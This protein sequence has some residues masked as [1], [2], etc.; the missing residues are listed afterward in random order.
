MGLGGK[1]A[2]LWACAA[3][4]GLFFFVTLGPSPTP[5]HSSRILHLS[6]RL[7]SGT[8][9]NDIRGPAEGKVPLDSPRLAAAPKHPLDP[10]T[11]GEI[12]SVRATLSTAG[13]LIPGKKMLHGVEL[14]EPAKEV[15]LAWSEG[16]PLP[17]R[18][19]YATVWL[20]RKIHRV[21]VD[22]A[23]LKVVSDDVYTG[24]GKPLLMGD[25]ITDISLIPLAFAPFLEAI[26]KRGVGPAD[27]LCAPLTAGWFG[28]P[29]EADLRMVRTVCYNKNH[30]NYHM[31]PLEG[32]LLFLDLERSAV[33]QF[34]DD[35]AA[36]LGPPEPTEY[37]LKTQKAHDPPLRP[38]S[39][40]QP[41]G[42]N[43]KVDG[44]GVS[45]GRWSFHARPHARAGLIL[46]RVTFNDSTAGRVRDIMYEGHLAEMYVPYQDPGRSWFFRSYMDVG[47]Y[48]FGV[49][50]MGVIPLND[51]PRNAHFIDAVFTDMEGQPYVI[52]NQMC[53]FERYAGNVAWRHTDPWADGRE[54][55][56]KVTLVARQIATI[57]NYDYTI[58]W[59]FQADGL[60]KVTVTMSGMVTVKAVH[61]KTKLDVPADGLESLYGTYVSENTVAVIHDHF[62]NFRLDMDVDGAANSFVEGRLH[63][64]KVPPEESWRKSVWEVKATTAKTELEG[65]Y[66]S[67]TGAPA[68]YFVVNPSVRTRLGNTVS[69]KL[70]PRTSGVPLNLVDDYPQ[71]RA[72]WTKNSLWVTPRVAAERW[73]G[74]EFPNQ[75]HGEDTLATWTLKDRPIENTDIVVWYTVGYHHM[76]VQE[77]FPVMPSTL[78]GFDIKPANFFEANPAMTV[79]PFTPAHMPSCSAGPYAS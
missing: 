69:Y 76:P 4:L 44:Y 30:V 70:V 32:I 50:S 61:P 74:G 40:E 7:R 49:L 20:D 78:G 41:E 28:R 54:A 25:E 62:I 77:D 79:A 19:A 13:L 46:S 47:E 53:I 42:V 33:V 26:A 14:M 63:T 59:E 6:H 56:P 57:G 35:G 71:V 8:G 3:F 43:F 31:Q 12:A 10:L 52:P 17:P 29:E 67:S 16:E 5:I 51:C 60:I 38:I 15:V 45:W 48:G 23:G 1:H 65:Q 2:S 11:V 22:V 39:I 55:R 24:T 66:N 37:T 18:Q 21:V 73:P 36:P 64:V 9:K 34:F 72:A 27:V 68:E 58:D 75:Q